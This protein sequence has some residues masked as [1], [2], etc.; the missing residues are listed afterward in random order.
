[1][2]KPVVKI[3]CENCGKEAQIYTRKQLSAKHHFCSQKLNAEV[4]A[5]AAQGQDN[6]IR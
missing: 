3:T 6:A 5:L 4:A 1:M 2:E